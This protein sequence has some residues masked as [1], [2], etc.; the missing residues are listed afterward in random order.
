MR[1]GRLRDSLAQRSIVGDTAYMG[2]NISEL[3][4]ELGVSEADLEY[5]SGLYDPNDE[6]H[7]F[8]TPGMLTKEVASDLWMQLQ[9]HCERTVWW[10]YGW[11]RPEDE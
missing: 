7:T 9:P 3:A 6:V 10:L 5:M 8:E 1:A 11:P 2:R 4:D